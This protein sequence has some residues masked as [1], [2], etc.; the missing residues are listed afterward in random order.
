MSHREHLFEYIAGFIIIK[1]YL[2]RRPVDEQGL[3]NLGKFR[4]SG[5]GLTQTVPPFIST[6]RFATCS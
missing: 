6:N 1:I 2:N 5:A 4:R 3:H